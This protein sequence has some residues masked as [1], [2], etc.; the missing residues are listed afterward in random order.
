MKLSDEVV[1]I[2]G[3]LLYMLDCIFS[4]AVL[5]LV[6]ESIITGCQK[7]HLSVSKMVSKMRNSDIQKIFATGKKR[8]LKSPFQSSKMNT[9]IKR[10]KKYLIPGN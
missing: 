2:Q 7:K 3:Y 10:K 8:S 6:S 1:N 5:V 9:E 4:T